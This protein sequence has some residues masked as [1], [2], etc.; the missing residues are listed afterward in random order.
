MMRRI[1]ILAVM[2]ICVNG[3]MFVGCGA[4][5]DA[6]DLA[7]QGRKHPRPSSPQPSEDRLPVQPTGHD[8]GRFPTHPH[9]DVTPGS[10][11]ERASELR[12]PEHIKYCNRDVD[13]SLK[14]QLFVMY[15]QKFGYETRSME[16]MDFKIDHLI[17]LCMGGSNKSDNLW[18][19]H[20]SIYQHTDPLEPFL[21]ETLAAG[22]IKQAEA[23]QIILTVK[24]SPFTGLDELRKLEARF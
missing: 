6:S 12:Y 19:Q 22:K 13:G 7:G 18:P 23:V 3:L 4:R 8:D 16:R 21:C 17:P 1:G 15:D 5:N 9:T 14:A 24:Q 10:L 20:E 11:C 2:A